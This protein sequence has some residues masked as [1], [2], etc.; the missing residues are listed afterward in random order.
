[1]RQAVGVAARVEDLEG[2]HEVELQGVAQEAVE[3]GFGDVVGQ[4]L[5]GVPEDGDAE[6][7][8]VG[9]ARPQRRLKDQEARGEDHAQGEAHAELEDPGVLRDP[10]VARRAEAGRRLLLNEVQD[11][12][13]QHRYRA[14]DSESDEDQQVPAAVEVQQAQPL[15][16][17]A[18]QQEVCEGAKDAADLDQHPGEADDR[19]LAGPLHELR[20]PGLRARVHDGAAVLEAD[21][22]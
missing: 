13:E 10:R 1:M 9:Q 15:L 14:R 12:G 8:V 18:R 7:D 17:T 21:E 19:G 4:N 22:Q 3:V 20:V 6:G 2:R 11:G 16:H 5:E